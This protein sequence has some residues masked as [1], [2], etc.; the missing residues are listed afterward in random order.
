MNSGDIAP[1]IVMVT[2]I[3][4]TGG[5][6]LFRPLAKRLAELLHVMTQERLMPGAGRDVAQLHELIG[7]LESR[8]SLLEDRQ[9]FTESLLDGST[10][11]VDGHT[12]LPRARREPRASASQVTDR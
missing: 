4:T 12:P 9:G 8:L 1:M 3:L 7:R 6:L 11:G 2:A 10:A 5:V